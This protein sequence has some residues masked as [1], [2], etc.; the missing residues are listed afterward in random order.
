MQSVPEFE[1]RDAAN[2]SCF[3]QL[4]GNPPGGKSGTQEQSGVGGRCFRRVELQRQPASGSEYDQQK[5]Y[6]QRAQ[7]SSVKAFWIQSKWREYR[8]VWT[9]RLESGPRRPNPAEAVL[10]PEPI[11]IG[12]HGIHVVEDNLDCSGNR[13]GQNQ[14]NGTP[15][16]APEKQGNRD[17]QRIDP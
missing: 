11:G 7:G 3:F 1:H 12:F 14:S 2:N 8:A 6:D 16:R 17:C 13:N 5:K 15:H 9:A 10:L 4:G